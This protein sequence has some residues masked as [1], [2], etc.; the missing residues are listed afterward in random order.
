MRTWL[1]SETEPMDLN[2]PKVEDDADV[3]CLNKNAASAVF[4]Y[5]GAQNARTWVFMRE[6][7]QENL[8]RPIDTSQN[9]DKKRENVTF[10]RSW[11]TALGFN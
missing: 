7:P 1:V 5:L 10:Q 8:I 11:G 6:Q 4:S 2:I 9:L 3:S